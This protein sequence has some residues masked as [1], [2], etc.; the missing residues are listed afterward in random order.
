MEDPSSK[1]KKKKKTPFSFTSSQ[2]A[3]GAWVKEVNCIHRGRESDTL[4]SNQFK[5]VLGHPKC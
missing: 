1:R 3:M 4:L 2:V 5:V